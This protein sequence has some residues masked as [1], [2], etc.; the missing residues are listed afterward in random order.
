MQFRNK[1]SKFK[2]LKSNNDYN[3]GFPDHAQIGT[4]LN[5]IQLMGPV[6]PHWQKSHEARTE[7]FAEPL[8]MSQIK[9]AK[10]MV[11]ARFVP[12]AA[13]LE[14]PYKVQHSLCMHWQSPG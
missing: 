9:A 1:T 14:I 12:Q 11:D 4:V 2:R 5:P 7:A 8:C 6:E 3:T 13:E 10:A